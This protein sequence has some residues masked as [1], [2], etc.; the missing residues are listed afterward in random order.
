MFTKKMAYIIKL[1][2]HLSVKQRMPNNLQS[3]IWGRHVGRKTLLIHQ[4]I[5]IVH[6]IL[7]AEEIKTLTQPSM[8]TEA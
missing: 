4:V 8:L 7:N 1:I 6:G 3:L 2:S 5:T